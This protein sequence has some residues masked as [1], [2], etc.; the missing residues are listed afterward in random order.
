MEREM[1]GWIHGVSHSHLFP[2]GAVLR[3]DQGVHTGLEHVH[4]VVEVEVVH[5]S[6]ID[7]HFTVELFAQG[8]PVTLDDVAQVKVLCENPKPPPYV[9]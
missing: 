3:R 1:V 6:A 2:G 5:G 7:V 8:V 9:A 4:R